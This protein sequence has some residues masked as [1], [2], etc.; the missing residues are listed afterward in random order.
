MRENGNSYIEISENI[1]WVGDTKQF[2]NLHCNPYLIIDND[3]A[4]LIDPGSVLDFDV[5]YNNVTNLIPIEKIKYI[6]LQ[7]QDPDLCSS[8][9]LFEKKGFIGEVACHWRASVIITYYGLRSEFYITNQNSNKLVFS[10]GRE[11]VFIHTP[12]LHFPGAIVTYDQ[13]SK[14]L[15][16]SDLFGAL[17]LNWNLYADDSYFESMKTFHEHYMPGNENLRPIMEMFLKMDIKTIAPQHGSIIKNNVKDYIRTL[18]D[19][20]CGSYLKPI[21]REIAASGGY[22]GICN[23]ILKRYYSIFPEEEIIDIFTGTDIKMDNA[24]H[25][26]VDFDVTGNEL[27]DSL[28]ENIYLKKGIGWLSIVEPLVRKMSDEYGIKIPS[29]FNSALF[30]VE[31]QMSKLSDE[32]K[33]LQELNQRLE[34]NLIDTQDKLTKCPITKFYNE[35]FFRNYF[36]T[37][38]NNSIANNENISLLILDIDDITR[39]DFK[40]GIKTINEV[41][42]TL[43]RLL[44]DNKEETHLIFKMDGYSF[45]YL[46][47]KSDNE[48][49]LSL[50]EKLRNHI[51]DSKSFLE[52]I[53]VSIGVANLEEF[54]KE[55]ISSEELPS[56][57]INIAKLR[58]KIA[59]NKGMN[60]VCSHSS[61]TDFSEQIGKI[62]LIDTDHYNIDLLKSAFEQQMYEV[63]SASDGETALKLIEIKQP[64]LVI[65]EIMIPK[66]DGFVVRENML[67]SSLSKN[68]PFI[69][70]SY[71]KDEKLLGRA[72]SLGIEHYFQ[73]PYMF[74]ELIGVVKNKIK[75]KQ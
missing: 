72:L 14:T 43:S 42:L 18:R 62:L 70:M 50:A 38:I 36:N 25:L 40:F 64:D 54:E 17:S 10:S 32:N 46:I 48:T 61:L 31:E 29:I 28:F 16:S 34:N 49:T 21:K 30:N 73:K 57:I 37:E 52:P 2:N 47:P 6:I 63:F 1:F 35:I 26:I 20:E 68:I 51:A 44:S 59:K 45:A 56:S 66:V 15:F 23:L 65:S 3:E 41:I 27:W 71:Q 58:V 8:T 22:L 60:L 9:P 67:M 69:L 11:L 75:I 55:N 74:S 53:T 4:V 5:V 39:I 12:Y 24:T 7:H 19:L 13:K 33:K